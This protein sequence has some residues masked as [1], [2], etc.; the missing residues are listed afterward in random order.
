MRICGCLAQDSCSWLVRGRKAEENGCQSKQI[1]LSG[2][3]ACHSLCQRTDPGRSIAKFNAS[4]RSL[5]DRIVALNIDKPIGEGFEYVELPTPGYPGV[6]GDGRLHLVGLTGVDRPDYVELYLVNARP[7][8]HHGT[9]EFLDHNKVGGNATVEQFRINLEAQVVEHVKTIVHPQI[10]TPNNIAAVGDGSFYFT[11][12]HG[13]HKAGLRQTLSPLI[14]D[15][16]VSFCGVTGDCKKVASRLAF[17]NGLHLGSDR[18]LY[19]PSS[20]SG[21]VSVYDTQGSLTEITTIQIG[22]GLDNI[23]EDQEGDLWVPGIPHFSKTL[24]SFED[25]HN[26]D[27]PATI[28][29]ISK[30]GGAYVVYKMLEDAEGL[31]LPGATTAIHDAKTGRLFISGVASPFITVCEPRGDSPADS[32]AGGSVAH[33]EL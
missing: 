23:S 10:A 4:G 9:G 3:T 27:P 18:R 7:S 11:N 20:A 29:K 1:P 32:A 31:V 25:P 28:F 21:K 22:M 5:D 33:E 15:G 8:V 2:L 26:V 12:D 24:A 6:N 30:Q 19:V 13:P 16:D 14:K 17:P